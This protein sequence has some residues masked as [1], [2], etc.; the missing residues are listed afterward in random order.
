MTI[1]YRSDD[2][3]LSAED[4]I[5]LANRVWPGDY[6]RQ[7]A[8]SAIQRTINTTARDGGRLIGCVRILTDGYFFGTIP[9]ILVDPAYQRRGIGRRLMSLAWEQAP[10]GLFLGAQPGNERFFEKLG[11]EPGM[12]SYFRRKPRPGSAS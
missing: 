3:D 6:D 5:D 9:E 4:F 12:A 10:T 1:T 11:Y 8:Q 2:R 7:S